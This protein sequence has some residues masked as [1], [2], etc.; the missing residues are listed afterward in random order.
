MMA[1]P[2]SGV[3]R[4]AVQQGMLLILLALLGGIVTPFMVNSRM[5]VGAHTLG[6]LGGIVLILMG[7]IRPLMAQEPKVWGLM[8]VCWFIAVY[9]NWANTMLAGLTGASHLT[10]IAGA[11]TTGA[12]WAEAVVFW[13]Y[14]LVGVTSAT[15]ALVGVYGLRARR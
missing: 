11:G 9:A 4:G 13:G 6:L 12:P 5:G 2:G 10:P 3:H 7:L 15:G 1:Q 8:H 14:V